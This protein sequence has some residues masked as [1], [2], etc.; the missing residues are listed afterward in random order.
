MAS[1]PVTCFTWSFEGAPEVGRSVPGWIVLPDEP[2]QVATRATAALAFATSPWLRIHRCHGEID[3]RG[4][5]A[6]AEAV[7][8]AEVDAGEHLR[9]FARSCAVSVLHLWPASPGVVH[10]L[11]TGAPE[12]AATAHHEAWARSAELFGLERLAARAAMFAAHHDQIA[13]ATRQAANLVTAIAARISLDDAIAARNRQE[14][15]LASS[16]QRALPPLLLA[17]HVDGIA[18]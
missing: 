10:Y 8:L 11:Q 18:A 12:L 15:T 16:L 14:R 3:D 2:Q 9:Y 7:R 13:L 4:E 1:A 6:C 5:L 17:P